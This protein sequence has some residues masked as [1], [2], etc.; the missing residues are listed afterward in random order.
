MKDRWTHIDFYAVRLCDG[1]V[2]VLREFEW[3]NR[4]I[5]LVSRIYRSS[6]GNSSSSSYCWLRIVVLRTALLKINGLVQ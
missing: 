5:K 4:C 6:S 2:V 3:M 1:L